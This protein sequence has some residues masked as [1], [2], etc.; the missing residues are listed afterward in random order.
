M[1][2]RSTSPT[3]RS[4]PAK[5]CVRR[6]RRS[7][8]RS[9]QSSTTT[10]S[11]SWAPPQ[12]LFP[13]PAQAASP[14]RYRAQSP[15]LQDRMKLFPLPRAATLPQTLWTVLPGSA[16]SRRALPTTSC[17]AR[18]SSL[19]PMMATLSRWTIRSG[20]SLATS[21]SLSCSE[22]RRTGM[23]TPSSAQTMSGYRRRRQH[24]CRL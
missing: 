3:T 21:R 5:A 15:L 19:R 1:A 23:N 20:M 2:W 8:V 12:D 4:R 14:P 7:P 6:L 17:Q 24:R 13:R 9:R 22:T 18:L 11:Q 16:M 10:S